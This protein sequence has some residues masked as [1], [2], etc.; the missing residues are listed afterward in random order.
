MLKEADANGDGVLSNIEFWD[1]SDPTNGDLATYVYDNFDWC[2][3]G[4]RKI[5]KLVERVK[6]FV[7]RI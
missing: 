6:G 1:A 4:A 2:A 5:N 3:L 7:L